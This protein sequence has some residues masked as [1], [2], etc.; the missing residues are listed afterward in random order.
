[1]K[2]RKTTLSLGLVAGIWLLLAFWSWMKTP[3]EISL[4]E[5]RKLAQMPDLTGDTLISGTFPEKFQEYATDQFPL[6]EEFRT[7][8]SIA[9]YYL[10]QEKD[11]H[12]I[13][14]KQGYAAKIEAPL[15]RESVNR[16]VEKL[17][18]LYTVYIKEKTDRVYV[19]VIPDKGYYLA[20][21]GGYPSMDYPELFSAV[22][23][24]MEF[25]AYL[26]LK[27]FLSQEDYYRTDTHW[28][29][30]RITEAASYLAEAMGGTISG[31]YRQELVKED[32]RGVYYGQAALPMEGEPL[33]LL[34]NSVIDGCRV[35]SLE[36]GADTGVYDRKALEGRD[37]YEVYL[38]GPAPVLKITNPFCKGER[39]LIL[40][41]DSFSSSLAP[42][43]AEAYSEI[44]LVDIRYIAPELL[45][46]YIDFE[47]ADVLFL[48]STLLL[49]DS[50]AMR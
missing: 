29:Q 36:T 20:S 8:K 16:A 23:E 24:G 12:G 50:G 39:R 26:D 21:R 37:P 35:Y 43:L 49:N 2:R 5:R 46:D 14:L 40:F 47:N 22:K 45:G 38:S 19:S 9:T 6:R 25:A 31:D 18:E 48:Y 11:H 17:R 32:F 15:N 3:D 4:T 1:M 44:D 33:Y 10:F 34:R 7:L 30:E 27:E 13:Y 28:R 41:G 42:L